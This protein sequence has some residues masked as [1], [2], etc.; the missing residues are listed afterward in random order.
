MMY[1]C[2]CELIVASSV[3]RKAA[4]MRKA[5]AMQKCRWHQSNAPTKTATAERLDEVSFVQT[6]RHYRQ[7]C[8]FLRLL[9]HRWQEK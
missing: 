5:M 3:G 8:A 7:I 1:H 9:S 6:A 2:V 4:V